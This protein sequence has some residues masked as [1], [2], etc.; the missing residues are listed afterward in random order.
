VPSRRGQTDCH[1]CA[2]R[3]GPAPV[4]VHR[5]DEIDTIRSPATATPHITTIQPQGTRP[6]TALPDTGSQHHRDQGTGSTTQ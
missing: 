3:R 5:A 2:R 6:C 1:A 4:S